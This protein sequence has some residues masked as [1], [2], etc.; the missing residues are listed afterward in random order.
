MTVIITTFSPFCR[1]AEGAGGEK[2]QADRSTGGGQGAEG[3]HRQAR[4]LRVHHTVPV[5][6]GR[7]V[8]GLRSFH[9]HES[10]AADRRPRDRGQNSAGRGAVA[11]AQGNPRRLK[12]HFK[13]C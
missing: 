4:R 10:Q 8:L 2:V 12:L 9:R 3:E 1:P 13:R 6:D 5:S 7:R 11:R